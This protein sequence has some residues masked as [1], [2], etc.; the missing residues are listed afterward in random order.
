MKTILLFISLVV[1]CEEILSTDERIITIDEDEGNDNVTC[2]SGEKPCRTLYYAVNG[3]SNNIQYKINSPNISINEIILFSEIT[4]ITIIGKGPDKTEMKCTCLGPSN[5]DL[6]NNCGLVFDN[7]HNVSLTGFTLTQCSV[8]GEFRKRDSLKFRSGLIFFDCRDSITIDKVSAFKNIGF[9]LVLINNVGNIKIYS[10]N[11]LNNSFQHFNQKQFHGGAGVF[12]MASP[13]SPIDTDE[14]HGSQKISGNYTISNSIFNY[15]KHTRPKLVKWQYSL[16]YGGGLNIFLSW[17]VSHNHFNITRST[18]E[19]NKCLGG[20]GMAIVVRDGAYNNTI[21]FDHCKFHHNN[22]NL[23][24]QGGGGGI[25]VSL[26]TA[27]AN[28]D[29][30]PELN[31]IH[32]HACNFT[33]NTALYGGG[34][35]VFV[36]ELKKSPNKLSFTK[37]VWEGN[38][39]PVSAAVDLAP[40]VKDQNIYDF[41]VVPVFKDCNVS[42]NYLSEYFDKSFHNT[43]FRGNGVFLITKLKVLFNGTTIF[44]NNKPTALYLSSATVLFLNYA[45]AIFSNNTANNGGAVRTTGFSAMHYEKNARFQF[46]NNTANFLGGAVY[47]DNTDQHLSIASHTCFFQSNTSDPYINVT[48]KFHGNSAGTNYSN[49]IYMTALHP[50]RL[51][52]RWITGRFSDPFNGDKTCL[53]RFIMDFNKPH[54]IDT[55]PNQLFLNRAHFTLFVI[56]GQP[57]YVPLVVRDD[58]NNTITI[59]TIFYANMV[60]PQNKKIATIDSSTRVINN[61]HIIVN[62]RPGTNGIISF[63]PLGSRGSNLHVNF[64]I[65]SCPPGYVTHYI[66]HK[67]MQCTCSAN[68]DHADWYSG[69]IGCNDTNTSAF[70]SPGYWIGYIINGIEKPSEETL[71]TSDCPLGYCDYFYRS[72]VK[73]NKERFYNLKAAPDKKELEKAICA[74]NREGNLCGSCKTGT[75]VYYHSESYLCKEEKYCN[76]GLLFYAMSE[77]VPTMILFGVVLHFDI[78]LTSGTAYSV[79]FMIQQYHVL[80][81]SARGVIRFFEFP[82]LRQFVHV[83]YSCLNLDFFNTDIFSFCLWSGAGTMDILVMKY[84][85]VVFALFLVALFVLFMNKCTCSCFS[86]CRRRRTVHSSVVQGLTAFLVIS[87]SKCTSVTFDI[88]NQETPKGIGNKLYSHAIVFLDGDMLYFKGT[89]LIYAIPALV[90]LACIVIPPPLFLICDPTLLKIEDRI[91]FCYYRQPWTRI[92]N[93]FKPLLDTFQNCFKDNM[94][95]FAGFFFLYRLIILLFRVT[96]SDTQQYYYLIGGLLLTLLTLQAILQPFQSRRHN[97][98]AALS[99]CN[100]VFVNYLTIRIY[101]SVSTKGYTIEIIVLQWVQLVLIYLPLLAG[102]LWCVSTVLMRCTR[103]FFKCPRNWTRRFTWYN[104]VTYSSDDDIDVLFNRSEISQYGSMETD[105]NRSKLC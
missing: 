9:G 98:I 49:A 70:L 34:T 10:S 80:D 88:L 92:R 33:D 81:L 51:A 95:C 57:T 46:L 86:K 83:I 65:S 35:S 89:H 27:V 16:S 62:G 74:T 3:T 84:V 15:N 69:V 7:A 26:Y 102:V 28:K 87:Y 94:R 68:L 104:S 48:F 44:V 18:F 52:C 20:G 53:G 66:K 59:I 24:K 42:N 17:N 32:F 2:L 23:D 5:K 61:N 21:Y 19:G 78:S 11:F 14:C 82:G 93:R 38:K 64:T 96:T 73:F 54:Q 103:H 25:K 40:D 77:L 31:Q 58:Y 100:L 79:V 36:G 22:A 13:C 4:N 72:K 97:I 1:I 91:H 76:I 85:S 50:C 60:Y 63:S 6:N 90:F 67:G 99:F 101:N 30:L 12:I 47:I 39:S 43:S 29:L 55:E 105:G 37:C 75:T 71:Y 8:V 56:P 41:N 45:H